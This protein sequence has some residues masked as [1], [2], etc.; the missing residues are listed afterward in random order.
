MQ[1][2]I[3]G[4]TYFFANPVSPTVKSDKEAYRK[5]KWIFAYRFTKERLYFIFRFSNRENK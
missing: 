1:S 2:I 5:R 4:F 3:Y